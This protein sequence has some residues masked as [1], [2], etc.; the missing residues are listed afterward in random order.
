M[1]YLYELWNPITDTP[2]YVG[3]GV[4][5]RAE[6]HQA[7]LQDIDK[8][9]KANII[10][11]IL[12]NGLSV[13]IKRVYFSNSLEEI[14]S[15]EI[16][17]IAKYGRR[18]LGTGIL[19]NMTN[20]GDGGDT[21]TGKP[22][23]EIKRRYK[24]RQS[25]LNNKTDDEKRAH[26]E[27]ISKSIKANWDKNKDKLTDAVRQGIKKRDK[28]SHAQAVS[29]GW[30][31]RTNDE[32]LATAAK[33]SDIRKNQWKD[34]EMIP[35]LMKGAQSISIPVKIITNTGEEQIAACLQGWCKE[36]N[37]SYSVLWSILHGNGPK[38]NKYKKS[39]YLGW[40]V[41]NMKDAK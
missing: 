18:D 13:E 20:G 41:I 9:L 25:T 35:N 11:S 16:E 32:K 21:V 38:Q 33:K 26:R 31:N 12:I 2:F 19:A 5:N 15:K 36:H 28:E 14:N 8:S 29:D 4:K 22:I 40:Q 7:R 10:R 24:K 3:K 27:K 6:A 1:Y 17:L 37:E 39:K 23:E 34:P 30:K